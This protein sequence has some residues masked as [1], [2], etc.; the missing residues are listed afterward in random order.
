MDTGKGDRENTGQH[1][2]L[3]T[4]VCARDQT[5]RPPD[6]HQS[7]SKQLARVREASI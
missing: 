7:V 1:L 2:Y 6:K 4:K 3:A 5:A